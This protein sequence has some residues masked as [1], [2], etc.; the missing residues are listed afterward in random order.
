VPAD[1]SRRCN[2]R[3]HLQD[4]DL[5]LYAAIRVVERGFENFHYRAPFYP[6]TGSS[7]ADLRFRLYLTGQ[8]LAARCGLPLEPDERF[9][10]E[11][12]RR[13]VTPP[14]VLPRSPGV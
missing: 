11:C 14:S 4:F 8:E 13:G 9:L 2:I 1:F 5:D 6:A 7:D 10:D 12:R 3:D